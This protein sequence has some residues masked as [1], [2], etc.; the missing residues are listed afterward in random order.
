MKVRPKTNSSGFLS[1][2]GLVVFVILSLDGSMSWG[3][4]VDAASTLTL[5]HLGSCDT[6]VGRMLPDTALWE[7]VM[8]R[9]ASRRSMLTI[10][11]AFVGAKSRIPMSWTQYLLQMIL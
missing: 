7:A 10:V 11:D 9:G 4:A 3:V 5:Y 6:I 2:P 8:A 1:V